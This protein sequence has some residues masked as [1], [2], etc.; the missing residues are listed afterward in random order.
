MNIIKTLQKYEAKS[1]MNFLPIV[2]NKAYASTVTDENGKKYIDFTS[3]IFVA[4]AG[5]GKNIDYIKKQLDK[6]LIYA[7]DYPTAVRAELVTKLVNMTP[8]FV[9]KVFLLSTGSESVEIAC[10]LM[11][12]H[13]MKLNPKKR[14]IISFKDSMHGKTS[15]SEQ[16]RGK[17]DDNQWVNH[18]DPDICHLPFPRPSSNF[19]NDMFQL[20]HKYCVTDVA[21]FVIES[22]RGWNA[23]FMPKQYIQDLCAFSRDKGWLVAFDE[24]QGGFWRTG[25]MF[26]YMHY[27]VEPDLICV[28]K[29]LGG[30]LPISAVLGRKELLD[31]P[32]DLS[33]THSGNALCCAGALQNLENLEEFIDADDYQVMR[34]FQNRLIMLLDTF[35]IIKKV[36]GKGFLS[37]IIFEDKETADKLC[38][39]AMEKG[40][41]LVNT[42]RESVKL[43]PPITIFTETM[44]EGMDILYQ[45]LEEIS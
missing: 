40:L 21:G 5:H 26:A 17:N 2:W 31:L 20:S 39:K 36:N 22:Y 12:M 24:V 14:V 19:R 9:E 34:C 42:G 10:K 23:E 45:C 6:S 13:Q 38:I 37:A 28:G 11:R 25:P 30:G 3:G 7:Y 44:N 29:G 32:I 8:D 16:L 35:P 33:S 27:E 4:N 43:G 18:N 15:L 41:I 1:S